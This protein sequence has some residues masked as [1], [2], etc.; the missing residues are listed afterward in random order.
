MGGLLRSP[1]H[2]RHKW[3]QLPVF[4]YFFCGK[5]YIT[6]TTLTILFI[7]FYFRR[8]LALS[9]GWSA[10]VRSRLTATSASQVQVILLPQPPK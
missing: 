10:V 3:L 2:P 7:L 1:P 4:F 8:S 9:P 5:I 6:F